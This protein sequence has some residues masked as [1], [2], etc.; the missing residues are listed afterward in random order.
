MIIFLQKAFANY[1]FK[2]SYG[3]V[4]KAITIK[5]KIFYS[6]CHLLSYYTNYSFKLKSLDQEILSSYTNASWWINVNDIS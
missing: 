1:K 2:V 6:D 3:C 5:I 4:Q